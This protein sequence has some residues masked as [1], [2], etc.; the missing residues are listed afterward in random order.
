MGDDTIPSETVTRKPES[1]VGKPGG[2]AVGG[3]HQTAEQAAITGQ[4]DGGRTDADR[5]KTWNQGGAPGRNP[6][7]LGGSSDGHSDQQSGS[8]RHEDEP[9]AAGHYKVEKQED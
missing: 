2:P 5:Q 1:D 7:S 6:A 4:S 9:V 8:G 3:G